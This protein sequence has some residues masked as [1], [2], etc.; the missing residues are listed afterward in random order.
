[1]RTCALLAAI[2]I[3]AGCGGGGGGN[4]CAA[5]DYACSE[6][7]ICQFEVASCGDLGAAGSCVAAPQACTEEIAPV[8]TCDG[9]T[10]QNECRA[11]T[12]GHSVRGLGQCP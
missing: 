6:G 11:L 5:P 7:E 1:M 4:S 3:L 9:L 10:F 8:C 12:G 2:L